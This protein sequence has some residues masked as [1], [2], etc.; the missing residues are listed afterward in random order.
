MTERERLLALARSYLD[1]T[2]VACL[3]MPVGIER[4]AVNEIRRAVDAMLRAIYSEFTDEPSK[5]A[6]ADLP[7]V[8]TVSGNARNP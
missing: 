2:E 4:T 8:G 1:A 7:G 3:Q 6:I 5:L